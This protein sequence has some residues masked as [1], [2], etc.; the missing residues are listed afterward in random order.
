MLKYWAQHNLLALYNHDK[1]GVPSFTY[2]NT[3]V[4]GQDRLLQIQDAIVSSQRKG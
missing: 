3:T 1:W 4:F 2:E